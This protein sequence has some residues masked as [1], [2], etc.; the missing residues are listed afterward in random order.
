[1]KIKFDHEQKKEI[2]KFSIDIAKLIFG[3]VILAG[4]LKDNNNTF[5]TVF[6]GFF[7]VILFLGIGIYFSKKNI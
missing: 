7:A 5:V 3:G 4:I 1:M 2:G 6:S